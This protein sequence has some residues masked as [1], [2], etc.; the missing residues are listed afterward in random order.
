MSLEC[1]DLP[2]QHEKKWFLI[3]S[4]GHYGPLSFNELLD[5]EKIGKVTEK[6]PI[7]MPGFKKDISLKTLK[8]AYN[9]KLPPEIPEI[10]EAPVIEETITEEVSQPK[11]RWTSVEWLGLSLVI[12]LAVWGL[13]PASTPTEFKDLDRQAKNEMNEFWKENAK[14]KA[15]DFLVVTKDYEK[16]F[17]QEK[18]DRQCRYY[19]KLESTQVLSHKKIALY[20]YAYSDNGYVVF[21]DFTFTDQEH[22]KPGFYQGE[23]IK[24]QCEVSWWQREERA[25]T[26]TFSSPLY[27]GNLTELKKLLAQFHK[28]KPKVTPRRIVKKT[29]TPAAKVTISVPRKPRTVSLEPDE[30]L[31]R[32]KTLEFLSLEAEKK[33]NWVHHHKTKSPTAA[34]LSIDAYTK[35]IGSHLTQ[36][37]IENER[38]FAALSKKSKKNKDPHLNGLLRFSLLAKR[39]G[40][41]SMRFIERL[42]KQKNMT[43]INK[44]YTEWHGKLLKLR[45]DLSKSTL[46]LEAQSL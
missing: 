39:L 5:Y 46:E 41:D 22:L 25:K 26:I 4:Q 3:F 40:L 17:W 35:D 21:K 28:P 14:A 6:H 20:A 31:M 33:F 7:W 16:I 37:T 8:N 27:R 12:I 29:K 23:I 30:L 11:M 1:S 38:A 10:E 13:W 18:E 43:E 24:D 45:T 2:E 42:Q 36:L 15:L 34:K 44:S 9:L 19:L 32:L